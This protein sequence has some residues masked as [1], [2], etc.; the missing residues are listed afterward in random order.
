MRLTP[1]ILPTEAK[2][3]IAI[4]ARLRVTPD[5]VN[6]SWKSNPYEYRLQVPCTLKLWA[7]CAIDL[8]RHGAI[9]STSIRDGH[10]ALSLGPAFLPARWR[11]ASA[12][13]PELPPTYDRWTSGLAGSDHGGPTGGALLQ[14]PGQ[15]NELDPVAGRC[16]GPL[17]RAPGQPA[18]RAAPWSWARE[19][20]RRKLAA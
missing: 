2:R 6:D 13:R 12:R 9:H 1:P 5:D 20:V 3:T 11:V 17:R 10:N 7:A 8:F 15:P 14:S 19:K 18:R 16:A 4:R